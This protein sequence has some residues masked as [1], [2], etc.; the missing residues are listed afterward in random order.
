MMVERYP[1][2][3][4]EV[5]GSIPGHEISSLLDI[6]LARWSIA[7]CALAPARR[8]SI[9][10]FKKKRRRRATDTIVI[11][12]TFSILF[13]FLRHFCLRINQII[14]VCPN[15][16]KVALRVH[17][18]PSAFI[19]LLPSKCL[20]GP[21][22]LPNLQSKRDFLQSGEMSPPNQ[23][24]NIFRAPHAPKSTSFPTS[25][26]LVSSIHHNNNNQVTPISPQKTTTLYLQ[27]N[28]IPS[29]HHSNVETLGIYCIQLRADCN[30]NT[31]ITLFR[32]IS[33]LCGIDN[34]L[35]NK[36]LNMSGWHKP[37]QK[38][39]TPKNASWP[40]P[41]VSAPDLVTP[42]TRTPYV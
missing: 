41:K 9:L 13:K 22:R 19:F 20:P 10:N 2:P 23:N 15:E 31:C 30:T 11:D 29:A 1:N 36:F 42:V 38:G 40:T 37:R 27:R 34:I 33:V 18:V 8:P 5:G 26:Q 3:K 28:M 7:S 35:H 17:I 25:I 39:W 32:S 14:W 12:S 6:K 21:D 24:K 4:E 16:L